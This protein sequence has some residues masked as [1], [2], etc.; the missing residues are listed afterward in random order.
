M[1]RLKLWEPVFDGFFDD[2]GKP[3][4]VEDVFELLNL[5]LKVLRTEEPNCS[6]QRYHQEQDEERETESVDALG[7]RQSQGGECYE[8]INDECRQPEKLERTID[9]TEDCGPL[10]LVRAGPWLVVR[11]ELHSSG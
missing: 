10:A 4:A 2:I 11:H 5:L 8:P 7:L 9:G 3:F 1:L 6:D